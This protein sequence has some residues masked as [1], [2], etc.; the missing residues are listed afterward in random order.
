MK[1]AFFISL[2]LILSFAFAQETPPVQSKNAVYVTGGIFIVYYTVQFNY[3]RVIWE[4]DIPLL[5]SIS[6]KGGAGWWETWVSKGTNYTLTFSAMSG[7]QDWHLEY[8]LGVCYS[9]DYFVDL[10]FIP[11]VN[12]GL[13]YQK[14]GNSLIFRIG[15]GLPEFAYLSVGYSF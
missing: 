2:I 3:E 11:A 5:K 1:R 9:P 8:A 4:S 13:R 15:V 6:I 7:K 12:F 14:P 10:K